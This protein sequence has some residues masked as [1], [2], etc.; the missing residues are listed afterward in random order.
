M[1]RFWPVW[2]SGDDVKGRKPQS[3]DSCRVWRLRTSIRQFWRTSW[4][5]GGRCHLLSCCFQSEV[6][7]QVKYQ[8]VNQQTASVRDELVNV[9]KSR[10]F[11]EE[12]TKHRATRERGTKRLDGRVAVWL[13]TSSRLSGSRHKMTNQNE[14]V[15]ACKPSWLQSD[16]NWPSLIDPLV[17]KMDHVRFHTFTFW[18][19]FQ[20]F[21]Q[22]N[23]NFFQQSVYVRETTTTSTLCTPCNTH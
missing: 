6:V 13:Q 2:F 15:A 9:V 5:D 18:E 7:P 4:C 12:E 19:H 3:R 8:N 11:P 20:C 1:E 22:V 23:Q 10:D 14:I 21:P 16:C 17:W